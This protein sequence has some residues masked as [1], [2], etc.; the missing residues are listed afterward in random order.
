MLIAKSQTAWKHPID[1]RSRGTML[2]N[3]QAPINSTMLAIKLYLS[4]KLFQPSETNLKNVERP[5]WQRFE[6][7]RE[8]FLMAS[9][10][11]T[12]FYIWS[13]PITRKGQIGN[14]SVFDYRSVLMINFPKERRGTSSLTDNARKSI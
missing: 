3:L 5:R 14:Y 13:N 7:L 6:N 1:Q 8:K 4:K 9:V 10:L 11:R 2:E 12:R